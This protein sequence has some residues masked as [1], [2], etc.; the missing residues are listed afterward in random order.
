LF[1]AVKEG[2]HPYGD[3]V[4]LL[5]TTSKKAVQGVPSS[6]DFVFIDG[7]HAE[8]YVAQDIE[9]WEPKISSGGLLFGHDYGSGFHRGVKRA[10]DRLAQEKGRELHVDPDDGVW[11]WRVVR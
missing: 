1:E 9:L 5:R 2:L 3:R 7:N 4:V 10:V 8:E 11:W 6:L